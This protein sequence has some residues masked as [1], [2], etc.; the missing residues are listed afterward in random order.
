MIYIRDLQIQN[1]QN[2]VSNLKIREYVVCPLPSS[3]I[4]MLEK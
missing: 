1:G 3:S 4:E 2:A